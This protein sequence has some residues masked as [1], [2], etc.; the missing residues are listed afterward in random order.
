MATTTTRA[1]IRV[2]DLTDA[3]D[4]HADWLSAMNTIDGLISIFAGKGLFSA[5]PSAGTVAGRLY[6]ATDTGAYY[7]TDGTTWQLINPYPA[8]DAAAGTGSLRTLGTGALQ[9]AS[10]TDSRL[11]D[12]RTPSPLSVV[13]S[14]IAAGAVTFAKM[15]SNTALNLV[16]V[17]TQGSINGEANYR[18]GRQ[19]AR[20]DFTTLMGLG[21][22]SLLMNC[23][24][25]T[26]Q[27]VN[28]RTITNSG[29]GV[30]QNGIEGVATTALGGVSTQCAQ[31]PNAMKQ[32]YGTWGGWFKITNKGSSSV[33]MGMWSS[34][35]DNSIRLRCNAGFA[36]AEV[37]TGGGA[38]VGNYSQG[39]TYIDDD[40]W[41]FIAMTWDGTRL[42]L[43]VDGQLESSE[44]STLTT[45]NNNVGGPAN[46]S[47]TL[48]F[49]IFA[50]SAGSNATTGQLDEVFVTAD[51]LDETQIRFLYCKKVPHTLATQPELFILN[52][53]KYLRSNTYAAADFTST[54]NFTQ[55]TVGSNMKNTTFVNDYGSGTL[56]PGTTNMQVDAPS[57]DGFQGNKGFWFNG[58]ANVIGTDVTNFQTGSNPQS[59][60]FWI[61]C[62]RPTARMTV[63]AQ[64]TVA[65]A[66]GRQVDI[67]TDGSLIAYGTGAVA[68][69]A[70]SAAGI[71]DGQWHFVVITESGDKHLYVDGDCIGYTAVAGASVTS[72]GASGFRLGQDL[73]A[74]NPYTGY[75]GGFFY[76]KAQMTQQAVKAMYQK[77]GAIT[78]TRQPMDPSNHIERA[79]SSNLYVVFDQLDETDSVELICV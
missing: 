58:T 73:A 3:A 7:I 44:T 72:G 61:K 54:W 70:V 78:H 65:S 25:V 34:G 26:D 51:V 1:G 11:S 12:T 6:Y 22:P 49:G 33:L 23:A 28:A 4:A 46:Q 17:G 16:Q 39:M 9:A 40:R 37:S 63:Y 68:T 5:R 53:Q 13:S 71:A 79:D 14:T 69:S 76:S 57:Q 45:A 77:Q 29:L 30:G 55:P 42:C 62:N 35:T 67:L 20:T 52:V 2:P 21:E 60:G 19:L 27:S 18:A 41:H 15:G 31:A 48:T 59:Y 32:K 64:G 75:M 74:A 8:T 36:R 56:T 43:Y 10:G 50:D 66:A 24:A 47:A 38:L